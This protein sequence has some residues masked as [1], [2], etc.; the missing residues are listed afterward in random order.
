MSVL[1]A[2]LERFD[3]WVLEELPPANRDVLAGRSTPAAMAAAHGQHPS[4]PRQWLRSPSS[5]E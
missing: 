4:R 2:V 3:R 1:R 5:P